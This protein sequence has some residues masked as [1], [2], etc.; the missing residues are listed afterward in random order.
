MVAGADAGQL[1]HQL[2]HHSRGH[3][4]IRAKF[5]DLFLRVLLEDFL[6]FS[7]LARRG[8]QDLWR[9][10]AV[11]PLEELPNRLL[12]TLDRCKVGS[13]GMVRDRADDIDVVTEKDAPLVIGGSVILDAVDLGDIPA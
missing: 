11:E 5:L 10:V 3:C 1:H 6:G 12:V 7:E 8:G 9:R 13:D 4:Q 2:L